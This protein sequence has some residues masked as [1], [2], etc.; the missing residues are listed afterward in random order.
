M[1]KSLS[2]LVSCAL[3]L[4]ACTTRPPGIGDPVEWS[5]LQ[6]WAADNQGDVWDGFLKS[7]QKLGHQQWRE[8]CHL[9]E[10]S[11]DLSDAEAREFFESNF[12]ARPVYAEDGETRGLITGYYEPLLAG[13]WERSEE[14]R[15]PLYGV[16]KDL[17]IVD[18]GR[19]YPQLKNLRLRGK[20]VG[21][22]VVPYY[23]RAQLD[24]DQD[25][26]QGTEILW[27]NSLVDVFFLHVQ[28][29]G[30]IRLTDGSTVAVGYAGQNGHPYQSIGK[31][32]A[33]MGELEK[34][35]VTLFTIKDWLKSNPNRLN[36][37]LA[38]NPSYIFFELRN[39]EADGPVGALNVAL[40]PRRS[41]AVDR[42]VI[43]L[44]A[45][46]WLQT[47]L[48]NE[49]QSPLNQLMLA[50]DTGGAIKGHVRADVFWGRGDE[51]EKMAGLMKQQGR[52]FVLLPKGYSIDKKQPQ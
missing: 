15:Y 52:L 45:P 28:G 43:P 20:L 35:E 22:R 19:V 25:L 41:I 30:R 44:G 29:S 1:V 17:L 10:N 8:V 14:F 18:L 21:N 13:S 27:V 31:V 39:A 48:P 24:D 9:A 5:S 40:T 26:L 32:L 34:E 47:T 2:I 11:G 16:P 4:S 3:M 42:N 49:Q 33:E 37:V 23:D 6:N 12:E 7:C 51:A 50:Q 46:V 36:E 38:K